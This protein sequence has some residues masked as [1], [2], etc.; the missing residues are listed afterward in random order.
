MGMNMDIGTI[1]G[2]TIE[3]ILDRMVEK[4]IGIS[5]ISVIVKSMQTIKT[6]WG[7]NIWVKYKNLPS[8]MSG[9]PVTIQPTS[10]LPYYNDGNIFISGTNGINTRLKFTASLSET[11]AGY[12][13]SMSD[14]WLSFTCNG[15]NYESPHLGAGTVASN[16]SYIVPI[17]ENNV[18]SIIEISNI[19]EHLR[20]VSSPSTSLTEFNTN[21]ITIYADVYG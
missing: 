8:M 19:V 21:G 15:I 3:E 20:G 1:N 10:D 14:R 5:D 18:D 6:E 17:P 9:N 13:A 4:K 11:L 12:D 16:Y 2:L 7:L